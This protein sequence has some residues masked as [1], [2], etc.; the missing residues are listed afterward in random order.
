ML[1]TPSRVS[2][3]VT[4]ARPVVG[5]VDA[6]TVK[7]AEGRGVDLIEPEIAQP[8]EK[9]PLIGKIVVDLGIDL[10]A[11]SH[12]RN[13]GQIIAADTE[14]PGAGKI[15][16]WPIRQFEDAAAGPGE[17]HERD[18]IV[19][20][21]LS[22][23]GVDSRT[24]RIECRSAQRVVNGRRRTRQVPPAHRSGGNSEEALC[25]RVLVRALV[26]GEVKDAILQYWTRQRTTGR[27]EMKFGLGWVRSLK[28]GYAERC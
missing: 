27:F 19:R 22:I 28:Y 25:V 14:C 12:V 9:R 6:R 26:A 4:E 20:E 10:I 5:G 18:L 13:A 11:F 16:Q 17:A 7:N 24:C 23:S 2:G 3:T 15:R 8:V 1:L 21:W